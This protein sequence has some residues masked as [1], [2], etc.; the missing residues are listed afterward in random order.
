MEKICR[1]L[2]EEYNSLDAMVA[3]LSDE[4]WNMVT[5]FLAGV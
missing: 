1:D 5:P 3:N 2:A 4:E